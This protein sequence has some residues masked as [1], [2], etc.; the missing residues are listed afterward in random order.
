MQRDALLQQRRH[1]PAQEVLPAALGPAHTVRGQPGGP[2]L[3]GALVGVLEATVP[4]GVQLVLGQAHGMRTSWISRSER[5]AASR[6]AAE[7]RY[8][9]LWSSPMARRFIRWA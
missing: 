9:A 5:S 8:S 3:L 1:V 4:V 6:R 2:G 7:A